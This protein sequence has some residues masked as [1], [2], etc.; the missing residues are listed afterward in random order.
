MRKLDDSPRRVYPRIRAG[1]EQT[2]K[3]LFFRVFERIYTSN[4][5]AASWLTVVSNENIWFKHSES[6]TFSSQQACM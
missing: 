4:Q 1:L 2:Q 3:H 5:P 6:Y